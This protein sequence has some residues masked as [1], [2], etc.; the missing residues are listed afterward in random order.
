MLS[1]SSIQAI[2]LRLLVLTSNSKSWSSQ[3]RDF[4]F[5]LLL[6]TVSDGNPKFSLNFHLFNNTPPSSSFI[7]S[8]TSTYTSIMKNAANDNDNETWDIDIGLTKSIYYD[9]HHIVCMSNGC[10][11]DSIFTWVSNKEVQDRYTYE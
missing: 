3:L 4:D 9:N 11:N 6:P 8:F 10:S 7:K 5:H 1:S 2:K